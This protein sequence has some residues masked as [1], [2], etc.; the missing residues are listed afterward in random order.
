MKAAIFAGLVWTACSV[1]MNLHASTLG[2]STPLLLTLR[3]WAIAALLIS[4][5]MHLFRRE[6]FHARQM[7]ETFGAFG[8]FAVFVAT[9]ILVLRNNPAPVVTN[10]I[11]LAGGVL[12]PVIAVMALEFSDLRPRALTLGAIFGTGLVTCALAG[13]LVANPVPHPRIRTK[14]IAKPAE[15]VR[16]SSEPARA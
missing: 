6:K 5:L 4:V 11:T 14:Q 8:L 16:H 10:V 13:V 2:G 15:T 1:S 9:L 7:P 12:A 3:G